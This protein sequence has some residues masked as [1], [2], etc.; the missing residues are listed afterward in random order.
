MKN[1]HSLFV[2]QLKRNKV[3]FENATEE[4]ISLAE[5]ISE[6]YEHYESSRILIERSMEIS[7][8]ELAEANIKL[9]EESKTQKLIIKSLKG[10]IKD[11]SLD[12]NEI[13]NDDILQISQILKSEIKKR[14]I[15]EDNLKEAQK[16]AEE[17]LKSKEL[18]LANMS[19]EIRTPL[20][21]ILGMVWLLSNTDLNS[22]QLEYKDVLKT[23]TEN[24]LVIIN[25][26][27]DLSKI[28]SGKLTTEKIDF[29]LDI[30][31]SKFIKTVAF[32]SE[33]KGIDLVLEKDP[34]IQKL[35]K[36]D[37]NKINQIL[38]N[39]VGNAIKFTK[40]GSVVISL[41][42]KES[43]PFSDLIEFSVKDSGTGISKKYLK[44]IFKSFSQEDASISRK[45][46]GT[47]LGLTITKELVNAL[48][49]EIKVKSKKKKGA[50]FS[51]II[52]L[53]HSESEKI[54]QKVEEQS[55]N[56]KKDLKGCSILIA[57]DDIYNKIYLESIT[58]EWNV[59]IE[60]VENGLEAIEK[61]KLENFDIVLM[62]M[63]MPQMD[64]LTATK[65]IRNTLGLDIPIIA[66]TADVIQGKDKCYEAGMN[67]Y[68]S[69]PFNPNDLY[70]LLEKYVLKNN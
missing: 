37:P 56:I 62:D 3:N 51:F 21:A 10:S 18:F 20:N 64:G 8:L 25:D 13:E 68:I 69:K 67:D 53:L 19:H 35:L 55:L 7:N 66:L 9:V 2:R 65:E 58:E 59:T 33:Q 5:S 23:S 45:Y 24:L 17:S 12:G 31:L 34:K 63:H 57:E 14:K 27:L 70:K 16:I 39:L 15:V 32:K 52:E 46:G 40:E 43:K 49:G 4:F 47:G 30:L 54:T 36:G 38:V 22:K 44:N 61:L 48:G 50:K 60:I 29:N 41:K 1:L 26:I 11:I 42:L 6:S 28:S